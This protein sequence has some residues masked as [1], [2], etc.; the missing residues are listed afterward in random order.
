M[1]INASGPIKCLALQCCK[2]SYQKN[3]SHDGTSFSCS[4]G[5]KFN[6]N[7]LNSAQNKLFSPVSKCGENEDS[8]SSS[9]SPLY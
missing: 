1:S 8:H 5:L 2:G 7:S 9:F 3:I 4:G 6:Y